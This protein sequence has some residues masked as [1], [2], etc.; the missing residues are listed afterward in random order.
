M[1]CLTMIL[2]WMAALVAGCESAEDQARTDA[3]NMIQRE[4]A[5]IGMELYCQ[6]ELG[7]EFARCDG[8]TQWLTVV[9]TERMID[10]YFDVGDEDGAQAYA[11]LL[12]ND[13]GLENYLA[14]IAS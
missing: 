3:E 13:L 2:L 8:Y 14:D 11:C 4:A 7:Q 1:K 5:K 6:L 10:C 9:D 12:E